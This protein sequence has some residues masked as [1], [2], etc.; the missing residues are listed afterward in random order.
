M[1]KVSTAIIDKVSESSILFTY[2][3][4]GTYPLFEWLEKQVCVFYGTV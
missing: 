1:T 4:G 2:S 3:Q